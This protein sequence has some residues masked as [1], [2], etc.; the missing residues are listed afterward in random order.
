MAANGLVLG[1]VMPTYDLRAYEL[2]EPSSDVRTTAEAPVTIVPLLLDHSVLWI[3]KRIVIGLIHYSVYPNK[4][5]YT[6][7]VMGS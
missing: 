3:C 4:I 6:N 1:P 5:P 7:F 2:G